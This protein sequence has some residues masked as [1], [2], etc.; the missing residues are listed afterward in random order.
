MKQSDSPSVE[1]FV[2]GTIDNDDLDNYLKDIKKSNCVMTQDEVIRCID[3]IRNGT[4]SER[5]KAIEEIT[6]RNKPL[7]MYLIKKKYYTYIAN[8]WD[9]LIQAGYL[10]ILRALNKTD[11]PYNPHE[12]AFSTYVVHYINHELYDCIGKMVHNSSQHYQAN[13]KKVERAMHTLKN[14]GIEEP[15][16]EDIMEETGLGVE[17]IKTVRSIGSVNSALP[18]DHPNVLDVPGESEDEPLEFIQALEQREA[19]YHALKKLPYDERV[20]LVKQFGLNEERQHT[21]EEIAKSLHLTVHQ[22]HRKR[23]A[24]FRR[25]ENDEDLRAYFENEY[26]LEE[27]FDTL[28]AE[29]VIPWI[30]SIASI[31]SEMLALAETPLG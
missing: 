26:R 2:S 7:I 4:P 27:D 18:L 24:A 29:T 1:S 21:Q 15:T 3:L 16:I 17:A 19:L 8:N 11:P 5:D 10:G 12:S 31:E 30:V 9:D 25:L 28:K 6:I 22:V 13:T 23:A 14:R 20:I